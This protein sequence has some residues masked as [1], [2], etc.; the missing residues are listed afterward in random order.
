MAGDIRVNLSAT[1][2]STVLRGRINNADWVWTGIVDS[3][4]V[5]GKLIADYNARKELKK[6]IREY[7]SIVTNFRKDTNPFTVNDEARK[8]EILMN[9]IY[10]R[11][12][13]YADIELYLI[14][15]INK[16]DMMKKENPEEFNKISEAC[17]RE[18]QENK[19]ILLAQG[20]IYSYV[21]YSEDLNQYKVA[22]ECLKEQKKLIRQDN[23]QKLVRLVHA[24]SA[25]E[26]MPEEGEFE[27]L[28]LMNSR[29]MI[30]DI[31]TTITRKELVHDIH[32]VLLRNYLLKSGVPYEDV[33]EFPDEKLLDLTSDIHS[34]TDSNE[35]QDAISDTLVMHIE[36]M[37][38]EALALAY[39]H[40][41]IDEF[42]ASTLASF[43]LDEIIQ[44]SKALQAMIQ[45]ILKTGIITNKSLAKMISVEGEEIEETLK[46]VDLKLKE[47]VDGVYLTDN[48]KN[49][50]KRLLIFGNSTLENC[51]EE[52][53]RGLDF[54]RFETEVISLVDFK[55]LQRFYEA[56]AIDKDAI[57]HMIRLCQF[58]V[59]ESLKSE[60]EEEQTVFD[61][62][63]SPKKMDLV[64]FLYTSQIIDENDIFKF[65][66][67]N[68]M[69]LEEID[70]LKL[71]LE[72]QEK[73]QEFDVNLRK[74][75]KPEILVS[76]YQDFTLE[77]LSFM[78]LSRRRTS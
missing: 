70:E 23:A 5:D 55:N 9:K 59:F 64:N 19:K 54:S 30:P 36:Y 22:T 24:V 67:N 52:L 77:Y 58:D 46:T 78:N 33:N 20:R 17:K 61:Q 4:L 40:R 73:M 48:T 15:M 42:N 62:M 29:L 68:E 12:L 10:D 69:T 38:V 6:L 51:S 63:E 65:Y 18:M 53:I 75:I 34:Y 56:K 13:T 26:N 28:C 27:L 39:I 71:L 35:Y 16:F 57:E 76:A 49:K 21:I 11:I 37:D 8:L 2:S 60:N 14:Y 50:M 7:E 44:D 25:E 74:A 1:F 32:M 43:E 31:L 72:S 66:M 45:R 3:E 47:F 41:H